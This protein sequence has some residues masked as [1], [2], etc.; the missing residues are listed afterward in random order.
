MNKREKQRIEILE[1]IRTMVDEP[2]QEVG[3]E[4]MTVRQICERSGIA[5]GGFYHHFY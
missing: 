2:V 5:V 1:K 3:F 4:R